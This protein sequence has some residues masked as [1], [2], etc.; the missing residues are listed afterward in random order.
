M[1]KVEAT[2]VYQQ[3]RCPLT[4]RIRTRPVRVARRRK[5]GPKGRKRTKAEALFTP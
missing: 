5:I 3:Y 2:P 1:T 4:R